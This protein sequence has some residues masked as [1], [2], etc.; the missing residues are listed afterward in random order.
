MDETT[1]KMDEIK[2]FFYVFI[3]IFVLIY[4]KE[5]GSKDATT[6]VIYLKNISKTSKQFNCCFMLLDV[7][8]YF[9]FI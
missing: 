4:D 3:C 1:L 9:N 5:D 6:N 8:I 7:C 2:I